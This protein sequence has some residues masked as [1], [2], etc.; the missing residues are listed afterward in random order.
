MNRFYILS[1]RTD[2]LV[3]A[4]YTNPTIPEN[5]GIV[6]FDKSAGD[7]VGTK[8]CE[9]CGVLPGSW[10]R[11]EPI[12]IILPARRYDFIWGWIYDIFVTDR[13]MQLFEQAKFTGIGP[14]RANVVKV[15]GKHPPEEMPVVWDLDVIGNG[16]EPHPSSGVRVHEQ[17]PLCGQKFFTSRRNGIIVDEHNWDGSD[18]FRLESYLYL[19]ITERV[20][21][22]IIEH[23]LKPCTIQL[24]ETY[25][26]EPTHKRA[27]D[28]PP[29]WP[30]RGKPSAPI[31]GEG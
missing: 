11:H 21:D 3:E 29:R 2:D 19:F 10:R 30:V 24:P 16:G 7:Y 22:F 27:E 28:T 13:V 18:F 31:R 23:K 8:P 5:C 9:L 17:C 6:E 15:K 26:W 4:I 1:K 14:R 12:N 25:Q 20:K